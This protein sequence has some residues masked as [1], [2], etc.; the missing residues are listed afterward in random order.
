MSPQVAIIAGPNGAGKTTIAPHLLSQVLG[1]HDFVNA[2][3]I[4][5]GLSG[6]D[7]ESKSFEA[8][9]YMLEHLKR[10][11][12]QRVSFAF[13]TTLASR[14]FAPWLM[15]LRTAGYEVSLL[16]VW[17]PSPDIA[18]KRVKLRVARGGH[19]IPEDVIH[20]RYK[21]SLRNFLELYR[22]LA[23]YWQVYNGVNT[24]LIA[25]GSLSQVLSVDDAETWR[26]VQDHASYE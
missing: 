15:R 8:G 19:S 11:A 5:Q 12:S 17:L 7:P 16:Y 25:Q 1:I 20:R 14:T 18:A 10:L 21:R 13:E 23:D 2:D 3:V 9:R 4:A 24:E 26:T 6:F 22:P